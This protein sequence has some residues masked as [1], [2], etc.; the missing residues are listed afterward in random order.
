M[1]YIERE[2][3]SSNMHMV[4]VFQVLVSERET[5]LKAWPYAS[6]MTLYFAL[7]ANLIQEY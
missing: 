3:S 5:G 4:P 6:M 2:S 1:W 7:C